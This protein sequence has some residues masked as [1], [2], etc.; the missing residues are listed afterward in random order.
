M[1]AIAFNPKA[2]APAWNTFQR[3]LPVRLAAIHNQADYER[4]VEF[5]NQLL[6]VVGDDEE[7]ELADM[8]ELLG[9]LVQDFEN[10]HHALPDVEPG[11]VHR[12]SVHTLEVRPLVVAADAVDHRRAVD[13]RRRAW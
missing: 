9:Q 2:L 13:V 1:T 6:D 3:A 10:A 12:L 7:H 11:Q 4:A 5:M 8:L